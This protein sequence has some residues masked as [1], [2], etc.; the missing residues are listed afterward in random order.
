MVL[1]IYR[2]YQWYTKGVSCID[3]DLY[4]GISVNRGYNSY[5]EGILVYE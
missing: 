3:S 5:I 1:M 2:G 4:N